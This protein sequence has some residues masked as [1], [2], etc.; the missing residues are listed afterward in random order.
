MADT[1]SFEVTTRLVAR[2]LGMQPTELEASLRPAVLDDLPEVLALRQRGLGAQI[3]WNDRDYLTW[4][5]RLGREQA[6]LGEL[7]ISKREGQLLGVVGAE[8]MICTYAGRRLAGQRTMDILVAPEVRNSGLGIWLNQALFRN[9]EFTLAVGANQNSVGT[10]KRLYRM[11]PSRCTYV[12][13]VDLHHYLVRQLKSRT[14]A[15]VMAWIGNVAMA[16]WRR[17]ARTIGAGGLEVR[18]V[19]GFDD[20]FNGFESFASG[21]KVGEVL[22][23]RGSHYLNRRLFE[24]PRAR[25]QVWEVLLRNE[26]HGWIAMRTSTRE[27][28]SKWIH[29]VDL[30]VRASSD[31]SAALATLLSF[32]T[33]EAV[34]RKCTTVAVTLQGDAYRKVLRRHGFMALDGDEAN[35]VGLFALP[36]LGV[37]LGAAV[38]SLTDL[39]VDHDGY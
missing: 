2:A 3:R 23:N 8:E 36:P 11:L 20:R 26:V 27:D 37:E 4:R 24:N 18:Q 9:A 32:A 33:A 7:W 39:S 30:L 17:V 25:Y 22:V 28:G 15:M 6:G 14:A 21:E 31:R 12:H 35:V 34:R 16:C 1:P 13:P 5:Y 29:I 10:V 19:M 38:W